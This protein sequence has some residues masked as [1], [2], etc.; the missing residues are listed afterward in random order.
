MFISIF[1]IGAGT[2]IVDSTSRST[3]SRLR[4]RRHHAEQ[5]LLL[6]EQLALLHDGLN[7]VRPRVVHGLDKGTVEALVLGVEPQLAG[8][9]VVVA[10][11]HPCS[12]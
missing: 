1:T 12:P 3:V 5:L 11:E 4:P 2:G 7:L 10:G 9:T 6:R 8:P